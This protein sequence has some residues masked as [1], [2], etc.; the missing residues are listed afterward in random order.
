MSTR[1][2]PVHDTDTSATAFGTSIRIAKLKMEDVAATASL[3][4]V[5]NHGVEQVSLAAANEKDA[6]VQL[7]C[8]C[9]T[10]NRQDGRDVPAESYAKPTV[11]C[12]DLPRDGSADNATAG[13]LVGFIEY[14]NSAKPKGLNPAKYAQVAFWL[15]DLE[16]SMRGAVDAAD[17]YWQTS[18]R[19]QHLLAESASTRQLAEVAAM[20]SAQGQGCFEVAHEVFTTGPARRRSLGLSPDAREFQSRVLTRVD[21]DVVDCGEFAEEI[22]FQPA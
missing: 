12:D 16:Q 2:V 19:L 22:T 21:E 8:D 17:A 6:V 4:E 15:Q 1:E 18:D 11:A 13:A 14:E 5:E 3:V 10:G 7:G 20:R 9:P